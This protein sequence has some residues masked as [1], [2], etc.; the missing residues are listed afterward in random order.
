[1]PDFSNQGFLQC[2]LNIVEQDNS[3]QPGSK[4][5]NHFIIITE[6]FLFLC[7]IA[8][9]NLRR[10]ILSNLKKTECLSMERG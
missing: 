8:T 7:S 3:G 9:A 10:K 5:S 1:L 2:H 4:P 6:T